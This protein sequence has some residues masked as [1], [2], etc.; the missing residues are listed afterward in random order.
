M[1][2]NA[3]RSHEGV[4]AAGAANGDAVAGGGDNGQSLEDFAL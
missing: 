1:S 4:S 3:C 2:G